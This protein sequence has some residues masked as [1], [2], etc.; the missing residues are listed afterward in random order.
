MSDKYDD[1]INVPHH[2]SSTH[3]P[4]SL[5]NRAAQFAPFAA[6][7]GYNE[8]VRETGRITEERV[9]LSDDAQMQLNVLLNQLK[10]TIDEQPVISITYFLPDTTKSGGTYVTVTDSLKKI[11]EH[12]RLVVMLDDTKIPIDDIVDVSL[13][14]D[15]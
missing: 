5:S 4:M 13:V 11:E 12:E 15:E 1:I 3:P 6:L 14:K 10:D 7:T 8:A 9:Q 2:I